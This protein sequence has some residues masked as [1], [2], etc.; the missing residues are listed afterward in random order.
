MRKKHLKVLFSFIQ[1]SFPI[2]FHSFLQ[3]YISFILYLENSLKQERGRQN[4]SDKDMKIQNEGAIKKTS[5]NPSLNNA[6][7]V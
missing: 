7:K 6:N 1:I 2:F 3:R 5:G 4:L